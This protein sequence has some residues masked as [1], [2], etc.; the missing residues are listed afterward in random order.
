[1]TG[2]KDSTSDAPQKAC[3]PTRFKKTSKRECESLIDSIARLIEA[4]SR[5]HDGAKLRE[6]NGDIRQAFRLPRLG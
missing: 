6:F 3:Q 1:M 4:F 5:L 2:L